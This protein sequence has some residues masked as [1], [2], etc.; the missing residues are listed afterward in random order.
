LKVSEIFFDKKIFL[1]AKKNVIIFSEGEIILAEKK[2]YGAAQELKIKILDSINAGK[3]PLEIILE[4]A[5]LVGELSGEETFQREVREQ[6]LSVYG[7]ALGDK[8]ILENE[9]QEVSRRLEKIEAAYKNPDFTDEEHK[10]MEFAIARHKEELL[11]L[12]NIGS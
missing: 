7:F 1:P 12:Q 2:F 8:F 9:L 3:N 5:K 6:I 10:R 11:R 4:V